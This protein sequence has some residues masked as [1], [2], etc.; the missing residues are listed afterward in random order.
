MPSTLISIALSVLLVS[1]L[2]S[3]MMWLDLF[4]IR[5]QDFWRRVALASALGHFLLSVGFLTVAYLDFRATSDLLG[6]GVSFSAYLFNNPDLWRVFLVFDTLA[7]VAVLGF[8]GVVDAIGSGAGAILGVTV[9][10]VVALGTFQWYAVGGL[11]GAG[12]ARLVSGLRT[13][14]DEMPDWF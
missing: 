12:L 10:A 8:L 11:V 7:A 14:E 5:H 4:G 2:Y 13:P 9:V 6:T 1:G 3:A